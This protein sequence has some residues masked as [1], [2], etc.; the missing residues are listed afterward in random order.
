MQFECKVVGH[1]LVTKKD[2]RLCKVKLRG[3][4]F[5]DLKVEIFVAESERS[6]FPL[7]SAALLNFDVQQTLSLGE[8]RAR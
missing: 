4:G 6:E 8:R 7:G 1:E 2:E 3:A 5:Q